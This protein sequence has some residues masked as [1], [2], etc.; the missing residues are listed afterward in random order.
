M[1]AV[2]G[3][4]RLAAQLLGLG[5]V[6]LGGL[7]ILDLSSGRVG[8]HHAL[9]GVDD[10]LLTIGQVLGFGGGDHGHDAAS[11]GQDGGVRGGAAL[12]GDDGQHLV[13]VD[14]G[15]VRGGKILSHQ[16][17]RGLAFRDA[18]GGHAH[19]V[20]DHALAHIVQIGGT[21]GLVSADGAE[22]VLNCGEAFQHGALCGF[23]AVDQR[24]DAGRQRGVGREHGDG[25]QNR[26]GLLGAFVAVSRFFGTTAQVGIHHGQRLSDA[27]DLSLRRHGIGT[28]RVGRL[29]QRGRHTNNRADRHATANANTLD[30]HNGSPLFVG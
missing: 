2:L 26:G 7:G 27:V 4:A 6:S 10:D 1:V 5:G 15:G 23:A 8:N 30:F 24:G 21:L 25:L 28:G 29:R 13:Q 20:S 16:H 17:E 19:Q 14:C 3:G 11:A 22:H 9:G 12:R 18:G